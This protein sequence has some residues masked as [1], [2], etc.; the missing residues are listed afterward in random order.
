MSELLIPSAAPIKRRAGLVA[1]VLLAPGMFYLT[2][3]FLSPLVSLVITS[4]QNPAA[5][6]AIGEYELGFNISNYGYVITT[7]LPHI[8]RSFGYALAATVLA[9]LISYPVAYFIAVRLRRRKLLQALLLTLLVA[10]FFISFLLRSFAWKQLLSSDS[11]ILQAFQFIGLLATD[12]VILGTAPAVIFSL[13]YNFIPFMALPIY[14]NLERLDLKLIEASGDLYASPSQGFLWVTLPL[15]LPGI[16]SGTLLS[17]IPASGDFISA[18]RNF[19]GSANTQMIGNV[20]EASYFRILDYPSAAAL[21]VILMFAIVI[22]VVAYVR[23]S[24]TESL[25]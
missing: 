24:G 25:L 7:Y 9:L 6:G 10:P 21:S 22:I 17:F 2:L 8:L 13:T 20:V 23:R 5:S 1:F 19:F 4:L 3:F 15:S 16:I 12:E 14:A 11:F 18:S